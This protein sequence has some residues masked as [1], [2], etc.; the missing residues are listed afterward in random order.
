MTTE[1]VLLL[2]LFAFILGG[3]FL[4]DNGPRKVFERS[5]PRL[6]AR[7]ESQ[8]TIG[9]KFRFRDGNSIEWARPNGGPPL[10]AP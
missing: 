6:G 10:G 9:R 3:A 4:G 5:A 2:G 7:V 8:I 1:L